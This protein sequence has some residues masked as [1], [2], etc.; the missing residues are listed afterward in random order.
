M[1]ELSMEVLIHRYYDK[2]YR[3]I[4][5]QTQSV[6]VSEDISQDVFLEVFHLG[7]RIKTIVHIEAYIFS[8]AKNAIKL[9]WR[10]KK[11]NKVSLE[12]KSEDLVVSDP[13]SIDT[14]SYLELT[15]CIE[16]IINTLPL[17]QRQVFEMSRVE[18]LSH[19]EIA[20]RLNI[21][22]HTVNN[23]LVQAL[24]TLRHEVLVQ[25]D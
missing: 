24:K 18:G 5:S 12:E 6:V 7:E 13:D 17:R 11:I 21:S 10:Q 2:I 20:L 25:W 22:I 1:S 4:H 15:D 23:H 3:Y 14:L 8:M 9:N 19:N 16:E